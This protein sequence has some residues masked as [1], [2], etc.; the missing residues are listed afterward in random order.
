MTATSRDG[1]RLSWI[2][3]HGITLI[4]VG[5]TIGAWSLIAAVSYQHEYLLALNNG[6]ESWVARLVP[7]SV[8]G[9]LLQA[10]VALFWASRHQIRAPGPPVV[11]AGIGAVATIGANFVSDLRAPW[12]G[13]AVSG[14][15]GVAAVLIGW[16]A[17]W[18]L[19][20]QRRLD[21]GE[22]LQRDGN[23]QCAAQATT[24]GGVLRLT[25]RGLREA[26]KPAGQE[27]LAELYGLTVHKVRQGLA[28][29]VA[30]GAPETNG[31]GSHE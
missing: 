10:S 22:P 12:L 9:M 19:E 8:D 20:T 18:M 15:A 21:T 11:T 7:V 4:V 14:S 2:A 16:V 23:C 1:R 30:A 28:E 29:P 17:M 3:A 27:K 13:P 5:I 26:G 25:Q 6:Q 31:D 24:L